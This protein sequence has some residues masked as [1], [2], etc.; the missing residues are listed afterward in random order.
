MVILAPLKLIPIILKV[1][2]VIL[3]FTFIGIKL[4]VAVVAEMID[5]KQGA[6]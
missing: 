2:F 4:L 1:A 3:I 6:V 5:E